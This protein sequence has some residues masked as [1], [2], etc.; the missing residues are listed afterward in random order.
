MQEFYIFKHTPLY[1]IGSKWLDINS[2]NIADPVI[3][4]SEKANNLYKRAIRNHMELKHYVLYGWLEL[5]P[6]CYHS[7][8]SLVAGFSGSPPPPSQAVHLQ[9][10]YYEKKMGQKLLEVAEKQSV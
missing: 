3:L 5:Y 7:E 2:I 10:Q 1:A 4:L 8:T 6:N 9:L